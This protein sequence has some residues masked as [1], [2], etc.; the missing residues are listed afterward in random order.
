MKLVRAGLVGLTCVLAGMCLSSYSLYTSLGM[1]TDHLEGD[2]VRYTYYRIRW[3]GDGSF[4]IGGGALARPLSA[5][6]VDPFDLGGTFFEPARR[7]VPRSSW[8]HW[9]FWWVDE[10]EPHDNR[11]QIWTFWIGLPSWLPPLGTG[12]L[13]VLMTRLARRAEARRS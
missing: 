11:R 6:P 13:A 2:S 9:G 1:D 4:R 5:A 3:L 7:P 12:A 10:P 8:N